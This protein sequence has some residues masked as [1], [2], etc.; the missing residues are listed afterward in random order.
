MFAQVQWNHLLCPHPAEGCSGQ[1]VGTGPCLPIDKKFIQKV[2]CWFDV[3]E[4]AFGDQ[5]T[6]ASY[7]HTAFSDRHSGIRIF[8]SAL[9][10]QF[11]L[12]L[13]KRRAEV[14]TN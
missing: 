11:L 4:Q 10:M 3:T 7:V 6:T 5:H 8:S 9:N 13:G 12:F 14:K 1:W 2:V